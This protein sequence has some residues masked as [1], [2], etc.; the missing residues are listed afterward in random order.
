MSIDTASPR[1]RRALLAAALGAGAATVASALGRPLPARATD[2]DVIHVGD[3]LTATT[4]T[5]LVN[6]INGNTVIKA[7]GTN[8][9]GV[10]GSSSTW[11]GVEGVSGFDHGVRGTTPTPSASTR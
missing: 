8:G 7:E 9:T 4:T 3:D 10:Y 2:G 5:R 1:T 6:P 11:I